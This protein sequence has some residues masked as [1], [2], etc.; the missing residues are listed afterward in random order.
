LISYIDNSNADLKIAHCSNID[1][2]SVTSSVLQTMGHNTEVT[3]LAI[4]SDGLGVISYY[5]T[6]LMNLMVAHCSNELC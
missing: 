6:T 1:C 2:T 3:S 5:Y 4:G